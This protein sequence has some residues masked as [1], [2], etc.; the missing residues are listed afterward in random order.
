M[1]NSVSLSFLFFL[2]LRTHLFSDVTLLDVE[3]FDPYRMIVPR[4]KGFYFANGTYFLDL[5]S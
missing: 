3:R 2:S 4:E 5:E 1:W